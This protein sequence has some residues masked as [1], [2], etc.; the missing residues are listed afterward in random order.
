ME[1]KLVLRGALVGALAGLLAFLFARIF[2]EPKIQ[3]AI[4]YESA[5]DAA[6]DALDKATGVAA[7]PEGPELFSRAIQANLGIGVG[8]VAFGLAMGILFAIVYT[9]CLGRVGS[10]RPRS[11]ALAVAAAGFM[12]IYLVPF[13]KYPAN[14]PSIGHSD[15]IKQ[16]GG[17]YLVMVAASVLFMVGAIWL[18]QRL[19]ERIGNWNATLVAGAAFVVGIG[20]VMWLLPAFGQLGFNKSNYGNFDTET[21]QPLRDAAGKIVFPGF[22]ADLL[23][24]FRFLSVGAQLILWS[25]LGVV[26]AP[27]AERVLAPAAERDRDR[28]TEHV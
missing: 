5:R 1:K 2:A 23:F 21:P 11:I 6:Q 18:G 12:A 22:P 26:F 4:D 19:R 8:M 7:P 15:T 17:L 9:A 24:E 20:I 28:E 16:R 10:M 25:V 27:L 14:P 13:M 3:A